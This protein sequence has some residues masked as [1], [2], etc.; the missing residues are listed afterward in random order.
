MKQYVNDCRIVHENKLK[1]LRCSTYYNPN[2]VLILTD[3]ILTDAEVKILSR[4]LQFSI[5]TKSVNTLNIRTELEAFYYK[6]SRN[7]LSREQQTKIK[8]SLHAI[9]RNYDNERL[10]KLHPNITKVEHEELIKLSK[11]QAIVVVKSDK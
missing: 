1:R 3:R 11:D 8:Q 5:T 6:I 10:K 7:I 9:D 2:I 4:C